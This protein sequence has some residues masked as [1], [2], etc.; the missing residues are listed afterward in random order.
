MT[1]S[2]AVKLLFIDRYKSNYSNGLH[3]NTNKNN[4]LRVIVTFCDNSLGDY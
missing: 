2:A 1:I 3:T 4:E